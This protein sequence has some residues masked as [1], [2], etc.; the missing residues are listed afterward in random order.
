[1]P[2]NTDGEEPT[3]DL[4]LDDA[5]AE[6]LA[7]LMSGVSHM[8][9][10]AAQAGSEKRLIQFGELNQ[11]LMVENPEAARYLL[12]E[13]DVSEFVQM[14]DL[15]DDTAEQLG[16]KLVDGEVVDADTEFSDIEVE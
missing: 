12:L 10:Q 15:D 7:I 16:V 4:T 14:V 6:D 9:M 5:P 11:R 1:M 2:D 13:S 8:M 3:F